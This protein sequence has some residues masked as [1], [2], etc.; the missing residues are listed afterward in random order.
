MNLLLAELTTIVERV[1]GLNKGSLALW[2]EK[3]LTSLA[4]A[5]VFIGLCTIT[6]WVLHSF[7]T[8]RDLAG[9]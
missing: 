9:I 4:G 8:I 2:A 5:F 3:P 7:G 6:E 1:K